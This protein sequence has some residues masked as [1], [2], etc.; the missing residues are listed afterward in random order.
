MW[1]VGGQRTERTIIL[2]IFCINKF[3][4][5]FRVSFAPKRLDLIKNSYE[6]PP[7]QKRRAEDASKAGVN[8]RPQPNIPRPRSLPSHRLLVLDSFIRNERFTDSF[9]VLLGVFLIF[10]WLD[11]LFQWIGFFPLPTAATR[12]LNPNEPPVPNLSWCFLDFSPIFCYDSLQLSSSQFIF[13]PLSVSLYLSIYL[14]IYL[15]LQMYFAH[16]LKASSNAS[17]DLRSRG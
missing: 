6:R 15:Y 7:C 8:T 13:S 5:A 1:F 12:P 14:S 10:A 17:H 3:G 16:G 9:L 4:F 11:W 2:L